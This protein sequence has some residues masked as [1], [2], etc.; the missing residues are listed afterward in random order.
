ML[1]YDDIAR[2]SIAA[3]IN[4]PREAAERAAKEAK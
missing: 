4:H 2:L 1:T 3:W